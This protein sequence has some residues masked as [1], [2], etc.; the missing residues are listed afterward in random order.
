[1]I[2]RIVCGAEQIAK[3]LYFFVETLTP[4][5]VIGELIAAALATQPITPE[6]IAPDQRKRFKVIEGGRD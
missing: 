4:T 6:T 1:V 3:G 2:R 5:M